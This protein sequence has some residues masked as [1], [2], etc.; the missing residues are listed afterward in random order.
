MLQTPTRRENNYSRIIIVS[1]KQLLHLPTFSTT[2]HRCFPGVI[3]TEEK[4][5]EQCTVFCLCF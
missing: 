4:F 1:K 3:Y 2:F 5:G